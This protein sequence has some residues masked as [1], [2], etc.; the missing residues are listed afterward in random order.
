MDRVR[1][2]IGDRTYKQFITEKLNRVV[3]LVKSEILRECQAANQFL[4]PKSTINRKQSNILK[5]VG[6]YCVLSEHEE[7]MLFNSL[8]TENGK[9]L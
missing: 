6:I 5:N 4:I 3:F 2:Q 1:R 9:F 7:N 8:I